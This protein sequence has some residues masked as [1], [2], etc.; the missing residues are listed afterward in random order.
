MHGNEL[1]FIES[2]S[3]PLGWGYLI[4]CALNVGAALGWMRLERGRRA[5]VAWLVV[6]VV[7]AVLAIKAFLGSP[8][9][10]P[11]LLKKAIDGFLGPVTFT[12]G[13]L[14]LLAVLYW[15]RGFFVRPV[16]AWA[17]LNASLLFMGASMTDPEFAAIVTKPDNVPIV[18]MVY[19]LGFF[20]WLG[21]YLGVQ[22]DERLRRG[23]PPREAELRDTV[24]VWPDLVYTELIVMVIFSVILIVW[25]LA[26]RAPLEQPANPVAT[27]N[28]SKAPWY[29][30]GLQEMLVFFDASIAG[31]IVPLLIIFGLMAIPYLDINPKGNGYYTI[32]ERKFSYVVFHF[33][34]LQL[35]ILLILVGTFMRGP[36]WNFFGLY[37]P[38]DPHKVVALNNVKLSEY[39]WAI[40]L[41]MG[42]PQPSPDGGL[43]GQLGMIIWREIVGVLFLGAYFIGL[44]ILL[45]RTVFRQFRQQMGRTRYTI[46]VLL[47]LMMLMLPLKMI[48][49]WTFNLSYLVSVPEYF[50]NF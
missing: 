9:E 42:V 35:W 36:N 34:F 47:L 6:A 4:V 30:L 29:F 38:R 21:A 13:T 11:D 39:F 33:G 49:R 14:A 46:M 48:L 23:E 26:L 25:S 32:A 22:N 3:T 18:G 8:L 7:F 27:P 17:G 2:I 44:P 12:L 20:T 24:L 37:E 19:L 40:W 41:G 28:P 45:G 10:L 43:L 50:F 5:A 16:V 31:V 1:E 15:R